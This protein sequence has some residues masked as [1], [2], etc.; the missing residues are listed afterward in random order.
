MFR[1][2]NYLPLIAVSTVLTL[3]ILTAFQFYQLR[4]PARLEA[5]AAADLEASVSAGQEL[6]AI[7]CASCH[8]LKGEG[9]DAPALNSKALLSSVSDDQLLSL[10]RTGVPL[11][12]MPAWGQSFGG[13]LTDEDVRQVIA[14]LRSWEPQAP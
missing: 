8:G 7:N 4:E 6:Y 5:A 2:E 14:F 12:E 1:R 3:A 9:V 13:S 10:I 11:T